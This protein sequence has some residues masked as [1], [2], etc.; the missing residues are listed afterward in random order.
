M[1]ATRIVYNKE[2]LDMCMERDKTK[3][4]GIYDNLTSKSKI[5]FICKCGNAIERNER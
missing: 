5:K 3:V 2:L 4:E 1:K